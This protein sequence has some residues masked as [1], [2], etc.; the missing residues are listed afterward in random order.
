[1]VYLV[2]GWANRMDLIPQADG[3]T[4]DERIVY[5]FRIAESLHQRLVAHCSNRYTINHFL[6]QLINEHALSSQTYSWQ[7]IVD[8]QHKFLSENRFRL[9][10]RLSPEL[11]NRIRSKA[12]CQKTSLANYLHVLLDKNDHLIN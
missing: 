2:S 5:S 3:R 9:S 1:M 8:V 4:F 11:Y 12:K 10:L 7:E 6:A